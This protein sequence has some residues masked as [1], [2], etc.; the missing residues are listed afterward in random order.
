MWA[1]IFTWLYEYVLKPV[2]KFIADLFVW[3]WN[4]IVMPIVNL[5]IGIIQVMGAVFK[6]LY[7]NIIQPVFAAI[8]VIFNWLWTYVVQ[9]VIGFISGAFEAIGKTASDIFN[10][11]TTVVKNVFEGLLGII[12]GPINAVIGF[13]NMMIDGINA[14]KIDI[15]EFAR[16]LFGGASRIGFNIPK[17]PALAKGGYVDSP[18]MALIG[19]AGPEVVTPLKD[20]ERMM[21]LGDGKESKVL[22][23]YAAP[24][25]SMDSEKEL[26]DSMRRAKVVAGW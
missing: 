19:E 7:E 17:I 16:D 4:N 15:P 2:F 13:I 9:P 12:R 6:W 14:I 22:N 3:I 5:I 18:T 8:G 24:N 20:F 10:G 11:I 25:V 23:Y 26:F 21:G 1:A